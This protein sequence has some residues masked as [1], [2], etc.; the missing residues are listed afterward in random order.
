MDLADQTIESMVKQQGVPGVSY[1]IVRDGRI[2]RSG[3]YGEV[4]LELHSP[5]TRD[6]VYE[7]G[8]M[9]KQFTAACVLM[10]VDEGKISLDDPVGK[11]LKDIPELWKPLTIRAILSH[12]AGLAEYIESFDQ[13]RADFVQYDTIFA[14]VGKYPLDFQ[15]GESWSYSNTGYIVASLLVERVSGQKLPDFM[16]K[17]IFTPL[18]MTH[19]GTSD[20]TTVIPNRAR[21]YQGGA[22]GYANAVP[23]SPSLSG[24]AGN[25]VSTVGDLAKWS[26]A[27]YAGKLL[28][29]ES[30]AAYM[31]SVHLNSGKD[32]KY[33]FGWFVH[34][35]HGQKLIE[36]GGNTL[37][38][39]SEIFNI[40]AYRE[41]VIILTN[42]GGIAP[43]NAARRI[44][45][46]LH[47][48]YDLSSR[49]VTDPKPSRS[50]ALVVTLRNFSRNNFDLSLFDSAMQ[51]MMGTSRGLGLRQGLANFGKIIKKWD[52]VDGEMVDGVEIARYRFKVGNA[53][54]FF[55]VGWSKD[56]KVVSFDQ[57]YIE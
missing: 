23:I 56:D 16:K 51:A 25:L 46:L 50:L 47:P 18:G 29:K 53:D 8:S 7:I 44:A 14:K 54:V 26:G 24:G 57:E 43:A 19:T 21:G 38:F 28:K 49:H 40:S 52:Y 12:T 45:G 55:E 3:A 15:P 41:S 32:S 27:L 48:E 10:L 13:G 33:A 37:G 2:V 6:S 34:N 20:P 5:A 31:T 17:R 9:T 4:N 11:H 39:S 42:L 36:H 22:K 35:D 30:M 1:A